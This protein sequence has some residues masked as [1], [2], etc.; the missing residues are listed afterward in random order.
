MTTQAA[1]NNFS[2]KFQLLYFVLNKQTPTDWMSPITTYFGCW[3]WTHKQMSRF[4]KTPKS[5]LWSSFFKSQR[6]WTHTHVNSFFF[7]F[8]FPEAQPSF[9]EQ[10]PC[11]P[12][13]AIS[14]IDILK[15]R[16]AVKASLKLQEVSWRLNDDLDILHFLQLSFIQLHGLIYW[17][18]KHRLIDRLVSRVMSVM[19]RPAKRLYSGDCSA[20]DRG[21]VSLLDH[22]G[23]SA[24]RTDGTSSAAFPQ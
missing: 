5:K 23:V 20:L 6:C 24:S 7:C 19:K 12:S 4:L 16:F 8:F 2:L 10:S 3:T 9:S 15:T 17:L 18:D 1:A 21:C 22:G 13:S 14:L 11:T